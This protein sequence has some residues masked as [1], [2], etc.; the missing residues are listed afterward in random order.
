MFGFS[1][2]LQLCSYYFFLSVCLENSLFFLLLILYV[3]MSH[4][5]SS[6]G[7]SEHAMLCN[8]TIAEFAVFIASIFTNFLCDGCSMGVVCPKS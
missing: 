8:S 5:H 2:L 1:K 3:M 4:S 7:I 6:S